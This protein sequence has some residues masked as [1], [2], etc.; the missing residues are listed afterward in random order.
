MSMFFFRFSA[1]IL[2][3]ACLP[4]ASPVHAQGGQRMLFSAGSGD[5]GSV[6]WINRAD[7]ADTRPPGG[8]DTV[9]VQAGHEITFGEVAE[10]RAALEILVYGHLHL[11]EPQ[12]GTGGAILWTRWIS[13]RGGGWLQI[14]GPHRLVFEGDD[15]SYLQVLQGGRLD[16]I[17][18]MVEPL[19]RVGL[20]REETPTTLRLVDAADRWV[21]GALVG[22]RLKFLEGRARLWSF[23]ILEN[24]SREILLD[25]ES[26]GAPEGIEPFEG[27]VDAKDRRMIRAA[28]G[29][30]DVDPRGYRDRLVAG[31]WVRRVDRPQEGL[32]YV[33][34][35]HD[36]EPGQEDVL[37]LWPP[38]AEPVERAAFAFTW[39]VEAGDPFAITDPVTLSVPSAH[40]LPENSAGDRRYGVFA[41]EG[42]RIA[43]ERAVVDYGSLDLR[44][45]ANAP[46]GEPPAGESILLRDTEVAHSDVGCC[47][48]LRR[49]DRVAVEGLHVRD[50]HPA[51]DVVERGGRW[52]SNAQRGHGICYYG[53]RG[54]VRDNLL[55]NLN[56]DM[57]YISQ[58]R[59][60]E[61]EGNVAINTEIFNGNSGE[62]FTFFEIGGP[63]RL[64]G[65]VGLGGGAVFLVEGR[66]PGDQ[67]LV[68]DN[69]FVQDASDAIIWDR[70]GAEQGQM[71]VINNALLSGR[72][73]PVLLA[74]GAQPARYEG[75]FMFDVTLWKV[76]EASENVI[77]GSGRGELILDSG[78]MTS[79]IIASPGLPPG[80][81]LIRQR[82]PGD[83]LVMWRN[84]V[85][86][87][88]GA[89]VSFAEG[90]A[91]GELRDN[92]FLGQEVFGGS[93]AR[94]R[95]DAPPLVSHNLADRARWAAP[96]SWLL[97][98]VDST[99]TTEAVG[100]ADRRRY[101]IPEA[102]DL[103]KG[104]HPRGFDRAGLPRPQDLP[105][106]LGG[107]P[108]R[109]ASAASPEETV[110]EPVIPEPEQ[111]PVIPDPERVP[112]I[113]DLE[114][115]PVT[116]EPNED[117]P[118]GVS[119]RRPLT[120]G[121]C[122]ISAAPPR[123]PSILWALGCLAACRLGPGRRRPR[124]AAPA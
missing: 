95:G 93:L 55:T 124:R 80:L 81:A 74:G 25:L 78:S 77:L 24:S 85:D 38:I 104:D 48:L 42:A 34:G 1:L 59:D 98:H 89:A 82:E 91:R 7:P 26:R 123:L 47:V 101:L 23:T 21:A 69:V 64:R 13:V 15:Q 113:P 28:P 70:G 94:Q 8:D 83:A 9:V 106:G 35:A 30:L 36:G 5:W 118:V 46:A 71:H 63:V 96:G 75:N 4:L 33:L 103:L 40:R 44:D 65:N 105:L 14:E 45:I 87:G 32:Y 120:S 110:E 102:S 112:V 11:P 60:F 51:N 61:I 54:V 20:V 29:L 116:P 67:V 90:Q 72:L 31:R 107:L 79:N 6:G 62:V 66:Q 99:N 88:A 84:T 114:Q 18:R 109:R 97:A 27:R 19:G 2:I 17:G 3:A 49:V 92:I 100:W 111:E 86:A 115:E 41:G 117:P 16:L 56:D 12:A 122:A 10:R 37:V 53:D 108:R 52:P 50:I 22:Q 58:G 39:G 43:V 73:W 121:G 119:V 57:I 68:E 76:R